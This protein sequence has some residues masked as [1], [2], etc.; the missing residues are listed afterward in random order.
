MGVVRR[1]YLHRATVSVGF[2]TPVFTLFLLRTL[3]FPQVG[4]LSALSATLV[5]AFE[6]PTGY[7]ADRFGQRASLALGLACSVLSLAGFVVATSFWEFVVLYVLWALGLTFQSGSGDAWLYEVL[8]ERGDSESFTRVR[9]RGGAVTRY[10]SV[11][12]M[13]AGGA[14]YGVDPTYPFV[15]ALSLNALGVL[16]LATLP[17]VAADAESVGVSEALS[18]ARTEFSKPPLRAFLVAVAAFLATTGVANTYVQPTVVDALGASGFADPGPVTLAGFSLAP[19]LALGVLY[20]AFTLVSAVAGQHAGWVGDAMGPW[21]AVVGVGALA[22]T[23]LVVPVFVAQVAL[24]AFVVMRAGRAVVQPVANGYVND[25]VP[26]AGRATSL[27]AASMAYSLVRSPLALAA[28]AY[29][30]LVGP[31]LTVASLGVLFLAVGGVLGV[32]AW[33]QS[34]AGPAVVS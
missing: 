10:V 17:A 3:S 19:G 28:G 32:L 6:V 5:V 15:F 7:V 22:A 8:D 26:S 4:A 34:A 33:R 12:G 30:G 31:T 11:L 20:A 13:V 14:L 23:L 21:G 27:S 25:H 9:G 1:Y 16:V 2:I 29:A 24:P 18:V